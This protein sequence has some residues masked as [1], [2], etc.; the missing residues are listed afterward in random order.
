MKVRLKNKPVGVEFSAKFPAF[1]RPKFADTLRFPHDI[2]D[3]TAQNVSE[4]IGNYTELYAFAN[5][6]V[7]R[8][9]VEILKMETQISLRKASMLREQPSLNAQERWRRDTVLDCDFVVIGANSRIDD[10]KAD[11]EFAL[12]AKDNFDRYLTALSRELTRKTH[13]EPRQRFLPS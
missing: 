1:L 10:F 13:E 7:A 11:K 12:M 4:L 3:L 9:T 6:E 8:L 5:A 2:T